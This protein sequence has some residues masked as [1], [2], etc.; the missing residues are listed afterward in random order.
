MTAIN[1][2]VTRDAAH[3]ITD[4]LLTPPAAGELSVP[5]GMNRLLGSKCYPLPH[6]GL[7][8][9]VRGAAALGPAIASTVS[10]LGETFDSIKDGLARTLRKEFSLSGL[11]QLESTY[12]PEGKNLD[13]VVAGWSPKLNR[14]DAFFIVTHG[15]HPGIAPWQTIDTGPHM[16]APS[17][18]ELLAEFE[19]R[20]TA[21]IAADD[22]RSL[23]TLAGDLIDRQRTIE[24]NVGGFAQ[25]TTIT[26]DSTSSRIIARY[27]EVIGE[28]AGSSNSPATRRERSLSAWMAEQAPI[29]KK[30]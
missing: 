21:L 13:I 23:D 7:A 5:I 27:D 3:L 22:L 29:A 10:Y 4:G 6:L 12:G 16:I 9:A 25:V 15:N 8:V 17:R 28:S 18:P 30:M 11:R 20:I 1:V 14:P 26:A 19:P 2:I 24:S